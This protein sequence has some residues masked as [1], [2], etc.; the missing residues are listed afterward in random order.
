MIQWVTCDPVTGAVV[1]SWPGLRLDSSLPGYVGR[2]DKISVSLPVTERPPRWK[3][4]SEPNRVVLVAHYD[5]PDQSVLWAGPVIRQQF[6]SGQLIELGAETIHDWLD[7]QQVGTVFAGGYTVTNRDLSLILADML[8]PIAEYFHGTITTTLCGVTMDYTAADTAD[9]S[10]AS[11][12]TTIMGLTNGPEYA[13]SWRWDATGN[14]ETLIS[15]GPQVGADQ[16]SVLLSRNVEW[17]L[18][19]DYTAGKGATIVTATATNSG[20]TRNQAT[21][22]ATDLLAAG[23]LP[24]E[25]RFAPDTGDASTEILASHAEA[26]RAAIQTGTTSV[27]LTFRPD[28]RYLIGRDLKI[29][30]RFEADLSNPDMPEVAAT[31][32]ARLL[33]WVAE[34]DRTTGQIVKITPV[35]EES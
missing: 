8:G 26:K 9:K 10:C 33:G 11:V 30:D 21:S 34:A 22:Y 14:L 18:T 35:I 32:R 4:G 24:R 5:D 29:G 25:Y 7:Q 2:G 19:T 16:P 17:E 20:D 3:L 28:G 23:Y 31:L 27:A 15:V 6:G 1:E 13:L 12:A